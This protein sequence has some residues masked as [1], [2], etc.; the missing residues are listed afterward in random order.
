MLPLAL[1]WLALSVGRDANNPPRL[2]VEPAA[3][4]LVGSDASAQILVSDRVGGQRTVDRTRSVAYEVRDPSV[5]VVDAEGRVRPLGDGSTAVIVRNGSEAATIRVEVV[6]FANTRP[7]GFATQVVP[8]LSKHGCNAGGCHGKATGQNGFRLSLLGFD[9]QFDYEALVLESR[10]RRIFPAAPERSLFLRKPTAAIPHGGGRKFA[11]GSPEYNTINRWIKSG[12]PFEVKDE[13]TLTRPSRS[14]RR[15]GCMGPD[16]SQQLR[17]TACYSDG[18][19]VDVTALAQYQSNAADLAT[20]DG[21]G[22]I[23]SLDG[24]GEAAI[25]VRFGGLVTVARATIPR[26]GEMVAWEAPA[27]EPTGSTVR[28]YA[29]LHALNLPPSDPCTDAEFARRSSLDIAGILPDARRGCRLRGRSRPGEA[30]EV[31]RS[32]FEPA[33]VC[34]LLRDEV[35]GHPPQPAGGLRQLHPADHLR[36]PRLG[37]PDARGE[38]ALRRVRRRVDRGQ[39]RPGGQPGRRLVSAA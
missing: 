28:F 33:G 32:T 4:R 14:L 21:R 34:R 26:G 37:P 20:V 5:A 10:G 30:G 9:P 7:V 18:S 31:G 39:G 2:E 35:V 1:V 22:L 19:A 17:V 13:P 3:I 16:A 36:L 8:I 11:V 29:K 12:L 25:M 27:S 24:V 23:T 6:D 15:S 38:P